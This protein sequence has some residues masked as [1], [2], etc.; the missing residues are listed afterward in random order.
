MV[1]SEF[2]G[3]I[4]DNHLFE[5][6]D[7]VLLA[8]S[9]GLDSV[10]MAELFHRVNQPFAIAHVNFTLRASDSDEDAVFVENMAK[11]YG[12]PFHLVCYDTTT[13]AKERGLSIQMAARELRYTWFDQLLQDYSYACLATAHHKNDVLETLLLN[14]TR[15]TGLAGLHGI[16]ARQNQIVRP[17]LFA[18]REQLVAFVNEAGLLYREDSSNADDKYARNRIRHYVVPILNDLNPGLWQTVPRTVERLRAAEVLMRTELDRSWQTVAEVQDEGILLPTE[19]LLT[20]PEL[21]FRLM[22]WLKPM[23]FT[24]DQ[25]RQVADMLNKPTGHVI[26]STTHRVVH[27]RAGL[28]IEV[29]PE[30]VDINL[31]L[32]DWPTEVL[33]VSK[34]RTLTIKKTAKPAEFNPAPDPAI[35]SLDADQLTFPLR[36]RRWKQGDKVQ[37]LG[38][39][40]HKLVSDLL[41]DLKLSRS[42]REQT[43][44]LLS[45]GEIAWVVG[46]RIGHRFRVTAQTRQI[47]QFSYNK[48]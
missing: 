7:Q 31:V 46:R 8:V 21:T 43:V 34:E 32:S 38:L 2:L 45:G 13:V 26:Q 10:V 19:K 16:L 33:D 48:K 12:V 17:L 30:Q 24:T 41:N 44:V 3:F 9:G 23:G 22:E 35:A 36:I 14:L 20:L 1:E 42:E 4:N 37:P 11:R 15:G 6:T 5:S 39:K 27:E 18:T 25:T 28:F 40:G 47:A 29:L